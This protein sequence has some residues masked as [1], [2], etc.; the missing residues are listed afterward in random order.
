M[1]CPECGG[2]MF[3]RH[4]V[5]GKFYG[6]TNFPRCTVTHSAHQGS[7]KPLGVPG[8]EATRKARMQAHEVFDQLWKPRLSRMTRPRAYAWLAKH[9]A[10]P[11][12][13]EMNIDECNALIRELS[14]TFNEC[15]NIRT[16]D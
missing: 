5:F 9:G 10:K 4:G 7:G 2:H 12:I 13:G 15:K 11:H 14:N 6:C 3:L 1:N 8:N 16:E